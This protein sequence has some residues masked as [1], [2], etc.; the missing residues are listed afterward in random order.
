MLVKELELKLKTDAVLPFPDAG[1][2]ANWAKPYVFAAYEA[3]VIQGKQD[4]RFDPAA[5]VIDTFRIV[6]VV[7]DAILYKIPLLDF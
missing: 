5:S 1:T 3:G 7:I 4:G 6:T 2:I